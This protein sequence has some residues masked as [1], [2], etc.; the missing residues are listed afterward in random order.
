MGRGVAV[1]MKGKRAVREVMVMAAVF[2]LVLSADLL[3]RRE[4]L[5]S[6]Q[7]PGAMVGMN[8]LYARLPGVTR[9]PL[10]ATSRFGFT[11][12]SPALLC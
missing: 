8:R 1:A 11:L 9:V 7:V 3:E 10:P 12:W 2:I 5:R 6:F 4:K